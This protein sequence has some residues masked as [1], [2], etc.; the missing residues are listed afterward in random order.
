M[1]CPM[2]GRVSKAAPGWWRVWRSPQKVSFNKHFP[3]IAAS[4]NSSSS[5]VFL[6]FWGV[7]LQAR[8]LLVEDM[9][10]VTFEQYTF[11][12]FTSE[13]LSDAQ[14][15]SYF[16]K[17]WS[18]LKACIKFHPSTLNGTLTTSN[19][20][21]LCVSPVFSELNWKVGPLIAIGCNCRIQSLIALIIPHAKGG[22]GDHQYE[23][24][25]IL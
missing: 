14:N 12:T 8:E 22:G 15:N 21:C 17:W 2:F 19:W 16:L 5:D 11:L 13:T 18:R 24:A 6:H 23:C 9:D 1:F 25:Q 10:D 3:E 4:K 7:K 20:P